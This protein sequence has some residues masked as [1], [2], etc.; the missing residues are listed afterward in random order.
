MI[1]RIAEANKIRED[2]DYDDKLISNNEDTLNQ[3]STAEELIK[4][5]RFYIGRYE[6][7]NISGQ[8][9]EQPGNC[10]YR[11]QEASYNKKRVRSCENRTKKLLKKG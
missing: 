2:S 3:I 7:A 5:H 11:I 9:K 10:F 1:H 4:Y 6:L 8:V